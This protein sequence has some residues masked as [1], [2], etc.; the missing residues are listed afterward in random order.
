MKYTFTRLVARFS[1]AVGILLI[2][3]GAGLVSRVLLRCREV[4]MRRM[5]AVI[6]ALAMLA[7]SSVSCAEEELT[8]AKR[9]DIERLLRMTNAL[10]LGQMFA[11]TAMNQ[12][13]Q[14]L[15][16]LRP[17][18]SAELV[19]VLRE[20][21]QKTI[22]ESMVEKGGLVDRV[23]PLYHRYF[24]HDDIKAMLAF[25]GTPTGQKTISVMPQ[26]APESL[27]LGQ[28]WAQQLRPQLEQ[29]IK[30]RLKQRGVEL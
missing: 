14:T 5:P 28:Q 12:F 7:A 6:V 2:V 17:D 21:I 10:K 25:Y 29:R 9:A 30:A 26:L 20:E 13:E 27:A 3:A 11:S 8:D 16:Q 1:I 4:L 23:I 19:G 24:S 22:D 15:R 18:I